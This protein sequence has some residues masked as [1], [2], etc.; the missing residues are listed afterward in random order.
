MLSLRGTEFQ[1]ICRR[2]GVFRPFDLYMNNSP[3]CV[4]ENDIKDK[5]VKI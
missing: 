1:T 5:D 2:D 3:M 4:G